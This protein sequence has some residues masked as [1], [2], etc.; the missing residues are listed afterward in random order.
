[1]TRTSCAM[2]NSAQASAAAFIVGQSESLPMMI[3]TTGLAAGVAFTVLLFS[4]AI[5]EVIEERHA[6]RLGPDANFAGVVNGAVL[7]VEQVLP[8][9]NDLELMGFE[10]NAQGMPLSRRDPLLD[11]V[12]AFAAHNR[13]NA[14][15][16]LDGLVKHHIVFQRVGPANIVIVLVLHPPNDAARLVLFARD[17]LELHL[18]KTIPEAG[19]IL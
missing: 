14:A 18:N 1:M 2:P 17:G 13:Q 9:E 16:A 3:P 19:V 8:V 11:A 4:G 10:F 12:T 5:T 7:Y 6:I 15:L